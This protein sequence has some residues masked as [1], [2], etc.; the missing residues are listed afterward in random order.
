MNIV[1]INDRQKN[2]EMCNSMLNRFELGLRA[3]S[4]MY[5]EFSSDLKS[6]ENIFILKENII[7]RLSS[8]VKHYKLLLQEHYQ[9]ENYLVGHTKGN[10]TKF[11]G[12][13]LGNPYFE[14]IEKD[15]SIIFDSIV[16]N[17]TSSFD[18]LSHIISYVCNKNKQNT[19]YWSKLAKAA[20]AKNND[21]SN[22]LVKE[23]I[24]LVDR[25]FVIGLYD[26]RSRLIHHKRDSHKF[27]TQ[28]SVN[29][30]QHKIR[31]LIS[32]IAKNHF[33][34]VYEGHD[35]AKEFTL[36]YLSFWLIKQTME[37]FETLLDGL[38]EEIRDKSNYYENLH[39][40]KGKS[41]LIFLQL[42]PI[43]NIGHPISKGFWEDFKNTKPQI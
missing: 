17:I 10:P 22:S 23:Q 12:F 20:R 3:V 6:K 14:R 43:T 4:I 41:S 35:K 19:L 7:Y 30:D 18:Y 13:I 36:T 15:I 28:Q 37:R 39:G 32:Q 21:I 27:I 9:A 29:G 42:D 24:D 34:K 16:F 1:D 38:V 5:D 8:A 26:Y 31:I 11:D 25:E 2:Y 40:H 33:K